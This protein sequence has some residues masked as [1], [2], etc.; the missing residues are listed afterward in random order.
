MDKADYLLSD[1]QTWSMVE[2]LA[3]ELV[4]RKTVSGRFVA[5][6]VEQFS[7]E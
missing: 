1:D 5:N 2:R 6:L 3:K 4:E 7:D